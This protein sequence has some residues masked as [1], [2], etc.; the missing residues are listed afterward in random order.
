[1]SGGRCASCGLPAHRYGRNEGPGR[2][3]PTA[4]IN[5]L[6]GTL[7]DLV[8]ALND[9]LKHE[10]SQSPSVQEHL[11]VACAALGPDYHGYITDWMGAR[12]HTTHPD[13]TGTFAKHPA[14]THNPATDHANHRRRP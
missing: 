5:S 6:R 2:Y 4:C 14:E 7:G 11:G 10:V 8:G 9:E 3:D 13:S 12:A 1:M